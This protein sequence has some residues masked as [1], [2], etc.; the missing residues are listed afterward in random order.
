MAFGASGK[1]TI[2]ASLSLQMLLYFNALLTTQ[3][4][5]ISYASLV[6]KVTELDYYRYP[7]GNVYSIFALAIWTIG[8]VLR[9]LFGLFG[10]LSESVPSIS[11]SLLLSCFPAL[12][13]ITFLSLMQAHL[14]PY[15]RAAGCA[16]LVCNI[17]EIFLLWTAVRQHAATQTARFMR[18]TRG[19][20]KNA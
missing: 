6:Q 13:C 11:A 8:E 20:D 5:A 3:Y 7:L 15:E 9:L 17:I 12:P 2:G 4:I 19:L 1:Q 18:L 14:M 16:L 10:N